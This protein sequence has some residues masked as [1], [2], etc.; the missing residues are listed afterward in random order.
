[1]K[2]INLLKAYQKKNEG[3]AIVEFALLSTIL[4]LITFGIISFGFVLYNSIILEQAS[5]TAVRAGVNSVIT[6]EGFTNL[7][8]LCESTMVD[9]DGSSAHAETT[10]ACIA[11]QFTDGKLIPLDSSK[12]PIIIVSSTPANCE[13]DPACYLTVN[14]K[15]N[16]IGIIAFDQIDSNAETSMYYE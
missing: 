15:F 16:N 6:D 7:P 9:T 10:A 13:P 4:I 8:P 3:A 11:K 5:K 14:I 12:T 1:M 2:N